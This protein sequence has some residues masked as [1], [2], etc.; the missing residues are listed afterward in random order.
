MRPRGR[1]FLTP[2][3]V[4]FK[5]ED[6]RRVERHQEN[7]K[8]Q[9]C[10]WNHR[11]GLNLHDQLRSGQVT[12]FYKRNGWKVFLEDF[13]TEFI[14]L[15]NVTEIGEK[16]RHGHDIIERSAA[17]TQRCFDLI[18]DA[19]ELGV[20]VAKLR[21]C[22]REASRMSGQ[23]QHRAALDFH[24]GGT[25]VLG[26]WIDKFFLEVLPGRH[27]RKSQQT[28]R[29]QQHDCFHRSLP[30]LQYSITPVLQLPLLFQ[31]GNRLDL[32]QSARSLKLTGF[33]EGARRIP[34]FEYLFTHVSKDF[35]PASF[36]GVNCHR[37]NI[38]R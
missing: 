37:N 27:S 2:P 14:E 15:G 11:D 38:V 3:L 8:T 13:F 23:E 18:E 29:Q 24:S 30:S 12:N 36:G 31:H 35:S 16:H 21:V 5:N 4:S 17:L 22:L 1:S 9:I 19:L 10:L 7:S 20:E 25:R 28:N 32:Q 34:G 26:H 33:H 6:N